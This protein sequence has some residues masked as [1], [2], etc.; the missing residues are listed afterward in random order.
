MLRLKAQALMFYNRY[1][2]FTI[3]LNNLIKNIPRKDYF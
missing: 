3:E 1:K 2:I